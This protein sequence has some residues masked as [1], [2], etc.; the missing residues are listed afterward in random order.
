[1]TKLPQIAMYY[2][3]VRR[4]ADFC[5]LFSDMVRD[6]MTRGELEALIAKRP[7]V[8]GRFAGFLPTLPTAHRA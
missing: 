5:A 6:G 3:A 2:D 8:Y 4:D 7:N 1:M